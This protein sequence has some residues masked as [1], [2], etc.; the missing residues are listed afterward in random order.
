MIFLI[1]NA[2]HDKNFKNFKIFFLKLKLKTRFYATM[3]SWVFFENMK[4][5]Y[6]S[7]F[8]Q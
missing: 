7:L 1:I 6:F 3:V 2:N 4:L 5:I 8:F